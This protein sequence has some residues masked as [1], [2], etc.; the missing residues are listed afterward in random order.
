MKIG[1]LET[2]GSVFLAP[3]AGVTDPPF[4]RIVQSFGVSAVWTEMISAHGLGVRGEAFATMDLTGHSVPTVFQVYGVDPA[5]MAEAA[6]V[7][8]GCG[9]AA[10][11]VNMGCP[12]KKIVKT[13]AG[14]ALMQDLPR[15]A[16]IVAAVRRVLQIPLTV[17]IRSGWDESTRTA[18]ALARAVEAEG[19]DAITVHARSRSRKH[20]GPASADVVAEVKEAVTIPVIG[21]GGIR[22]VGDA[23][24]MI[25]QTGCDG[26]MIGQG[27][28]GRPWL[29]AMVLGFFASARGGAKRSKLL[30]DVI[31]EH[32]RYQLE[33]IDLQTAVRRMR[34]HLAW[35]SKGLPGSPE[36]R[37][38]VFHVE[39]PNQVLESARGF[40]GEAVVS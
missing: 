28:L 40:F 20:S 9:A 36:F 17:K 12:A 30:I 29:P 2:A 26:V 11:D 6:R 24:A 7:L 19:A 14:A 38:S 16:R 10:V 15:A 18:A 37:R 27:A 32:Y 23:R 3:M 13:G 5:V 35:Y 34:K 21:N 1:N 4:R 8:Q 22:N 33:W 25:E 31:E 39:D